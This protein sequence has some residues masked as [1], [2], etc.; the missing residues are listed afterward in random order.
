MK[1]FKR[2]I[3]TAVVST[4]NKALQAYKL[5]KQ[6]QSDINKRIENLEKRLQELEE[7]LAALIKK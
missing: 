6:K 2:D 4:D 1:N 5:K 7:Q 3:S